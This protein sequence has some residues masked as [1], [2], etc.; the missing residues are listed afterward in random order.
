MRQIIVNASALRSGGALTILQQFIEAIPDDGINYIVFC[1]DSITIDHSKKNLQLVPINARSFF[2]RFVWD[3]FRI[4]NWVKSYGI[5]PIAGI[6]LQN[7]NF[8]IGDYC[9]NFI[10]YH[11]PI[12]LYPNNWSL[13]KSSERALWFYKHIYPFFVKLFLNSQTE[14]F[15]QLEFI[16]V[17]FSRRFHF[18]ANKI[19]VVFPDM[20]IPSYSQ[21]AKIFLDYK[22]L[23]LFYPA[24]ALIYKNHEVLFRS[25]LLIDEQLKKEVV[26]YL[27]NTS[28]EFKVL[29]IFK[30]VNIVFLDKITHDNVIWLFNNV[31]ALLFPSYI[32]TLGLPLI[33]AA[34]FGLPVLAADLPYAR[35]VLD[36]YTG[37][38][39]VNYKDVVAWGQA[40]IKLSTEEKIRHEHYKKLNTKSWTEFFD[41]IK[42][43]IS[44]V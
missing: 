11:Q 15:V 40:I 22:K 35:E 43:R 21:K 36:G 23:N 17:G 26:L 19:H 30:N 14:I 29:P 31:D 44:H 27:T 25:L 18:D 12:P 1:D 24:S 2:K 13:L 38:S 20:E 34:S 42:K 41:T 16:K 33:E 3:A 39:Y 5:K 32:E 8:R 10:Y 4:K 28:D 6:S 37:V 9:P 7:T